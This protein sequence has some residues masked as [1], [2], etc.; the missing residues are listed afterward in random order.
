M[1]CPN[2]GSNNITFRRENV[3]EVRG[4]RAKQIV[5]RTVGVC[6]DCGYT[7]TSSADDVTVP[8]KRKTWLWVLGWLFIFPIPLTILML[9][10]K[11]MKPAIKYAIIAVAW[12]VY[13]IIGLGNSSRKDETETPATIDQV[14]VEQTENEKEI[15]YINV[16]LKVTPNINSDDGTVLFG[17]STNL[18]EDTELLV[19]VYDDGEYTAQ[20]TAVILKDGNGYTSE[21]SNHGEGLKGVYH[22]TI[23]ISLPKLQTEKVRAVIGEH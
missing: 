8:R 10:N 12:I 1:G 6:K 11:T 9:R 5:H 15:D 2:C 22:V 20:D 4:N 16:E 13:L 19:T 7:W 23:T 18:P 17:I 14:A 3:G 21:F